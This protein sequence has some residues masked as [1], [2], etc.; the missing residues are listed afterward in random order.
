[1]AAAGRESRFLGAWL[2]GDPS[3]TLPSPHHLLS[4]QLGEISEN[5]HFLK[6][7]DGGPG[8][9][10]S[11]KHTQDSLLQ[12]P[13]TTVLSLSA[14]IP[15]KQEVSISSFSRLL[16]NTENV[17]SVPGTQRDQLPLS[18]FAVLPG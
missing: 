18:L 11:P 13:D 12:G 17:L 5:F 14:R 7:R 10:P 6:H 4:P 16:S 8:W 2:R 9:G 3:M 15:G 1:M